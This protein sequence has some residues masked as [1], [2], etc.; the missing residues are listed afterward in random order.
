[1]ILI[2][3]E[4]DVKWLEIAVICPI[5]EGHMTEREKFRM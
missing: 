5:A 4:S 2:V 1:M 3:H